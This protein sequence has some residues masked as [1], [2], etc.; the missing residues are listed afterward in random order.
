MDRRSA[1]DRGAAGLYFPPP[2]RRPPR[3]ETP[4]GQT[5]G[6]RLRHPG[7]YAR[8][9]RRHGAGF[10]VG[11]LM[12]GGAGSAAPSSL[13]YYGRLLSLP[14]L[15]LFQRTALKPP[16]RGSPTPQVGGRGHDPRRRAIACISPGSNRGFRFRRHA[17]LDLEWRSV[18][19]VGSP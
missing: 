10:G 1:S 3:V 15:F 4:A 14:R 2:P 19:A 5:G 17:H 12:A 8:R 9:L 11:T 18:R 16:G 6:D 7:N 13:P